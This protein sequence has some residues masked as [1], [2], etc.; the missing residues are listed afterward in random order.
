M[1]AGEVWVDQFYDYCDADRPGYQAWEYY[2]PGMPFNSN[3][4]MDIS[5]FSEKD[6]VFRFQTQYD[7][8]DDGGTGMGIYIDDF[9]IYKVSGGSFPPPFDLV[10]EALDQSVELSWSDL[11]ASGTED[12]QYDNNSF[13]NGITVTGGSAWAGE[14]IDLAGTSTINS[15]SVFNNNLVDTTLTISVFGQ[16]GSLFGNES[17]YSTT[18][19]VISGAWTTVED[20]F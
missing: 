10:G 6:V 2:G 16:F 17:A 19:D 13:N 9:R 11:N 12:F 5:D 1:A 4:F 20:P 7:D 8:N 18:I 3:V 14:R 15:I